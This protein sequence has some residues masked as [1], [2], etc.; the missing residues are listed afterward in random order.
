VKIRSAVYFNLSVEM[1]NVLDTILSFAQAQYA[2]LIVMRTHGKR[3]HDRL[4][5]GS[6]AD[7]VMRTSQRIFAIAIRQHRFC[8]F[9]LQSRAHRYKAIMACSNIPSWG[10]DE[11]RAP[12]SVHSISIGST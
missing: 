6:V 4:M 12:V 7:R 2:D 5:L 9:H 3:E 8:Y 10:R 11:N 1:E